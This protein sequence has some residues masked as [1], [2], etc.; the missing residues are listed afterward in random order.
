MVNAPCQA[1]RLGVFLLL[2]TG[3]APAADWTLRMDPNWTDVYGNDRHVLTIHQRDTGS[4]PTTDRKAAV[5]LELKR[6]PQL[7][8]GLRRVD[9]LAGWGMDVWWY[10]A[11]Y[12]GIRLNAA[13]G[14]TTPV[15]YE[16]SGQTYTSSD[17]ATVL[18][19]ILREDNRLE[20]W[21]ADFY[22][23]QN[24][25]TSA[26]A[27]AELQV[28]WRFGDFDND[29]RAAV[30]V[31]GVE[32]HFLDAS[33][34]YPRMMGPLVAFN[35]SFKHGRSRI[36]GYIGQSLIVG[37]AELQSS[38]RHFNGAY[39]GQPTFDDETH[40]QDW[41]QVAVPITELRLRYSLELTER[42]ALGAG[43]STSAWWDVSVPPNP[44]PA[45]G[46]A[47]EALRENTVVFYSILASVEWRF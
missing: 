8:M 4:T 45:Q 9:E 32:G 6:T 43:A 11:T 31:E 46:N 28:G 27:S 20:V 35:G 15:V 40:F 16:A 18:Y 37:R 14:A 42:W 30:G 10:G 3:A 26:R 13:G 17:P 36:E 24:L 29:Y 19:Y 1:A 44:V 2:V 47:G 5:E 7:G 25:S 23:I 39:S 12:E 33:S 41:L 38:Q 22:Y 34:N 21:T